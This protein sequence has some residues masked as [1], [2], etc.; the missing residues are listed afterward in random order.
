M[1]PSSVKTALTHVLRVGTDASANDLLKNYSL[2]CAS[3]VAVNIKT[4]QEGYFSTYV[5]DSLQPLHVTLDV[6]EASKYAVELINGD[7]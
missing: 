4:S 5:G 7:F 2:H 1:K 3:S 6:A